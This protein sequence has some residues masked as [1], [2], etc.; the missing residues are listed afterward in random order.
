MAVVV[1]KQNRHQY[2]AELQQMYRQ[3]Y[4]VF[5]EQLHWDLPHA[6][7]GVECDEFD[8]DNTVYLLSLDGEGSIQG[9][10][11]LIPTLYPHLI[12]EIFPRLIEGEFPRG[13][14]IWESSRSYILAE[15]RAEGIL[16]ELFL[17]MLEIGLLLEIRKITFVSDMGFLSSLL[18][19]GWEVE[20][21]GM[22]E[23]NARGEVISASSVNVNFNTLHNL[24]QHYRIFGSVLDDMPVNIAA[25]LKTAKQRENRF[26]HSHHVG[27]ITY[28]EGTT[29]VSYPDYHMLREGSYMERLINDDCHSAPQSPVKP[30]GKI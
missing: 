29:W 19:A 13:C 18:H 24:R 4:D 22:P 15:Q 16:G 20:L 17:A 11:R 7:D 5:V 21:L 30:E 26:E 14:H 6:I 2:G 1:T 28:L 8:T 3:R 25:R 27:E 9:S 10:C 12:S 23:T